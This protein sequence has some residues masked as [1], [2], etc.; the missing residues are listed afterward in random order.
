[1]LRSIRG[2]LQAWYALVLFG[3]VASFAGILYYSTRETRLNEID[4]QL[5]AAALYLDATLRGFPPPDLDSS[6]PEKPPHHPGP[7]R[8]VW[9]NGPPPGEPR[10]GF[11]PRFGPKP[12]PRRPRERLLADLTLPK[13]L[14]PAIEDDPEDRAYFVVW[15]ADGSVL[16]SQGLPA[17][18][19]AAESSSNE[20]PNTPGLSWRG[21]YRE[22]VMLGPRTTR[23]LV[24]RPAR[25]ELAE[26]RAFAWQLAGIGLLVL[27]I[28]LL[29]GWVISSRVVRPIAAI[30]ATASTISAANLSERID[31]TR[32]ASELADLARVLNEMFDRLEAAFERQARFTAD[33]SHELRTPLAII[34]THSELALTRSRSA[35]EYR[36]VIETCLRASGRMTGLVEGL[37]TLARADAGKLDLQEQALALDQVVVESAALVRPL[38]QGKNLSLSTN[39]MPV[40]VTGDAGRL[41]QI[42][43]NLLSNAIQYNRPGGA[44]RVQLSTTDGEAVLEVSDTGCGIPAEDQPHLFERFY[45]VD[46][47][48]SRASGGNGLGLAIC[49]SIVEAHGGAIGF[50][51]ELEK[52]TTFW[53]RLPCRGPA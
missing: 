18:F 17:G 7:D 39:V 45:R 25:K 1:M 44:I 36:E 28:G 34:R 3:V 29:G 9:D 38:A 37:L 27:G 32:V 10:K 51:S 41:G 48:R 4:R 42:V 22:V 15:R 47:A 11:E 13:G 49:K 33:A 16:K 14:G 26:L 24:G 31:S 43:T 6:H 50:E 8:P 52:G 12:P 30:S 40:E 19:S 21:E 35:E 2:R 53:V 20:F 5:E 23:I 46:K